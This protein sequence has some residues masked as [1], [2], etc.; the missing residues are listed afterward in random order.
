MIDFGARLA[1]R[2][3]ELGL[4]QDDLAAKVG[5]TQGAISHFETGIRYPSLETLVRL[6]EELRITLVPL[7]A[8]MADEQAAPQ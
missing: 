8:T 2:R 5:V 6:Q 4:S 3:N 7:W 1:E